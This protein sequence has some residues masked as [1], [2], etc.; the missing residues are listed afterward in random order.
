MVA[1]RGWAEPSGSRG[2]RAW[3]GFT[4][5]ERSVISSAI[6]GSRSTMPARPKRSCDAVVSRPHIASWSPAIHDSAYSSPTG[7]GDGGAGS[8]AARTDATE[9]RTAAPLAAAAPLPAAAPLG[10]PRG[11]LI[12]RR[13]P[14]AARVGAR[15]E[16]TVG[17]DGDGLGASGDRVPFGQEDE[18]VPP[19]GQ[20]A[21]DILWETRL[22]L[23]RSAALVEPPRRL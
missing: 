3:P 15:G 12:A 17:V 7:S 5:S 8:H 14:F 13:G 22:E 19:P 10:R 23:Q 11:R 21:T 2:C 20:L 18:L 6:R 16:D 1:W 9:N 4:S